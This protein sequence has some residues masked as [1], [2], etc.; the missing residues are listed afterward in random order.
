MELSLK[1]SFLSMLQI[2]KQ[3]AGSKYDKE[4]SKTKI[5]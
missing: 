1:I 5:L 3:L 4:L 2:I